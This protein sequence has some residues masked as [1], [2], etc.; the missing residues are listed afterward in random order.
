MSSNSGMVKRH[1]SKQEPQDS[2]IPSNEVECRAGGEVA[3]PEEAAA[4][5]LKGAPIAVPQQLPAAVAAAK[6]KAVKKNQKPVKPVSILNVVHQEPIPE[7]VNTPRSIQ[8]CR[9]H[10]FNPSELAS[11]KLVYFKGPGVSTDL[12]E[13]R[14]KAFEK[15]RQERMAQ[16]LPER[17]EIARRA[18]EAKAEAQ[19]QADEAIHRKLETQTRGHHRQAS[20]VHEVSP[21]RGT[22]Y[23]AN[24]SPTRGT[25]GDSIAVMKIQSKCRTEGRDLDPRESAM[26]ECIIDREMYRSEV[27]CRSS[28]LHEDIYL[29]QV[30]NLLQKEIEADD[31]VYRLAVQRD[32]VRLRR[33]NQRTERECANEE[34]KLAKEDERVRRIE[35][36]I[37]VRE[38]RRL[39]AQPDC[40]STVSR[41]RDRSAHRATHEDV[42]PRARSR[43]PVAYEEA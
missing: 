38:S 36:E 33:Y 24:R 10:G 20:T 4:P 2:I 1:P 30:E 35:A 7:G 37:A 5:P 16:V 34:R 23:S 18:K 39:S 43:E 14:Y 26:L 22:Q 19:A 28:D 25:V 17:Q 6:P 9:R 40:S 3:S 12:A 13:L 21:T 42:G 8:L 31:R 41:Q 11:Y 27:R 29:Q 15:R 32:E